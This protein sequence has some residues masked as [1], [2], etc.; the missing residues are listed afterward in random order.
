LQGIVQINVERQLARSLATGFGEFE[1]RNELK[2]DAEA[3]AE[4]ERI[5][6]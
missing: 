2:T 5:G 6:R 3:Q 1:V 4:L